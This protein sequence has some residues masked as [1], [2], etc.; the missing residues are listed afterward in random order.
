MIPTKEGLPDHFVHH[1]D[2]RRPLGL[3]RQIPEE[4][5]VAALA[6]APKISGFVSSK[7][8]AAGLRLVARPTSIGLTAKDLSGRQGR[9]VYSPIAASMN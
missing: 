3:P 8:R 1:Q 7:K 4:C 6:A 9:D 5:L 2:M